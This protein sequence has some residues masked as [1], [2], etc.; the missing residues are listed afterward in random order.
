M[1]LNDADSARIDATDLSA[2]GNKTTGTVTVTNAVAISGSTAEATA[3]LVTADTLVVV[4]DATVTLNDNPSITALNDIAAKTSGVV[5]AT[6][7]AASLSDLGSLNTAS[8]DVITVTVND[9]DSAAV[10]ATDLSTLGGKTAGTVTVT[11][12]VAI[13]GST[14]EATAALVTADTLV[15]V[16]DATVTLNDNP[17]ITALNDIAAK[18]S[19]VVTAT[20]DAASLSDLGSLNT[21]SADVITVTV[22]DADSA[23]VDATDL[24]TLGG[25]T[26]GTVTV[27]NAVAISGSSAEATAALVTADTLVVVEDATVTLNDN[28]SITALNDIAAKTSGVVTATL[29]AASLSDLGSLNTSST[30]VITVTV[31]DAD[32]AAVDATDLSTLGGKTAGTVTVTNA[33]AI[34]GS[35]AEATA[36]LV[37]ADTLVVVEDATVTLNDADSAA[38]D[39]TDLSAIGNKTTG[40]VT[41]TNAVAIS[42]STAE[43]TAALVTA[44][45]L[46]VVEDATVTLNDNPSITALNDIAAKTSGVM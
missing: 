3:A 18:T 11:N 6:L 8:T 30:D 34:S 9:D 38:I 37:T 46:V 35:T 1:T 29:D 14:A 40:T 7:D 25:K 13:S 42:G 19:G 32:S 5:T 2:I 15:V 43:A 21:A 41:V 24:S 10:D 27:T 33:V 44:D 31:N 16:E 23:A 22:N 45:T 39:A 36:A 4:E 12:A 20:L 28:P 26:A 17:S